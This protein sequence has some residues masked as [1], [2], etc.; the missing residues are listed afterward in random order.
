MPFLQKENMIELVNP[1][2]LAGTLQILDD[3]PT[4]LDDNDQVAWTLSFDPKVK[5]TDILALTDAKVIITTTAAYR[6]GMI[7]PHLGLAEVANIAAA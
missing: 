4:L 7:A 6:A 1:G 3:E 5:L 2:Q